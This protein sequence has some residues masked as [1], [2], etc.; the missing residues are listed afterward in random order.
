MILAD[1]FD[2][3]VLY[4]MVYFYYQLKDSLRISYHCACGVYISLFAPHQKIDGSFLLL[5][6]LDGIESTSPYH[7][8]SVFLQKTCMEG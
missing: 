3:W 6:N 1:I 4:S 8:Q 7:V 5:G 2:S